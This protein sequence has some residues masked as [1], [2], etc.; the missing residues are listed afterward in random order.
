[1]ALAPGEVTTLTVASRFPSVTE[2]GDHSGLVLLT[3]RALPGRGLPVRIRLGVV[4]VVRVPGTIVRRVSAERVRVRRARGQKRIEVLLANR[5][6]VTEPL[7]AGCT[8]VKL[9]R[10]RRLVARLRIPR[11]ELLPHTTGLI[12][13]RIRPGLRGPA[14]AE[15]RIGRG[16]GGRG[17]ARFFRLRL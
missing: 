2:P 1:V 9:R 6:N 5:G 17:T 16:C 12:E 11:R 15:V 13:L 10:G 8:A 7:R 3:T 14:L 4:V